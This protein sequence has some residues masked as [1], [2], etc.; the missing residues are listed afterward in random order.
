MWDNIFWPWDGRAFINKNSKAQ[1]IKKNDGF[2]YTREFLLNKQHHE[3]RWKKGRKLQWLK[4]TK[5]NI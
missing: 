4:S 1:N 3:R 2:D 5:I